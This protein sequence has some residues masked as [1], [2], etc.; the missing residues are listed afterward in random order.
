MKN[1]FRLTMSIAVG[2]ALASAAWVGLHAAPARAAQPSDTDATMQVTTTSGSAIYSGTVSFFGTGP[3]AGRYVTAWITDVVLVTTTTQVDLSVTPNRMTYHLEVPGGRVK[4]GDTLFLKVEGYQGEPVVVWQP[5]VTE[6]VNLNVTRGEACIIA[7]NDLNRNGK[8]EAGEPPLPGTLLVLDGPGISDIQWL[9]TDQPQ[10]H[11]F[12]NLLPGDYR[13][14]QTPPNGFTASTPLGDLSKYVGQ[15]Y[16]TPGHTSIVFAAGSYNSTTPSPTPTSTLP[17]SP[18]ATATA[19][20]TATPSPSPTPSRT[21]LPPGVCA[22]V[23]QDINLD[24]NIDLNVDTPIPGALIA[25]YPVGAGEPIAS[26]TTNAS[27]IY[28]VSGLPG[29]Q[30]DMV[31]TPPPPPSGVW[32]PAPGY[33]RIRRINTTQFPN[34]DVTFLEQLLN[35][36]PTPSPT[37]GTPTPS[38][39]PTATATST[40]TTG[41]ATATRTPAPTP[42]FSP[43]GR[44]LCVMPCND[45]N[46]NNVCDAGEHAIAGQFVQVY[47]ATNLIQALATYQFSGQETEPYCW[48]RSVGLNRNEFAIRA[49]PPP[50]LP[51]WGAVYASTEV[52]ESGN[53][54][55]PPDYVGSNYYRLEVQEGRALYFAGFVPPTPTTTPTPTVTATQTFTPTATPTPIDTLTATPTATPADTSTPTST[56]TATATPTATSTPTATPTATATPT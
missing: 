6:T 17:P 12:P 36:S 28:C 50:S 33:S 54:L 13:L 55:P 3:L 27:G 45:V 18:T 1:L 16:Q 25:I 44:G 7:F 41:P 43:A 52:N 10:P 23:L 49:I 38:A 29:A 11:C 8:Q 22:R 40:P 31:M 4:G 39:T 46:K 56:P 2:L 47:D 37:P 30:Y 9:Q 48:P 20:T 21:P 26:G 32:Q 5:G 51:A 19:T 24:G 15:A 14:L 34:I 42:T 53:P 35:L